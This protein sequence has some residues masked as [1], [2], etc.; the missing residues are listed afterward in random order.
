MIELHMVGRTGDGEG[1]AGPVRDLDEPRRRCG[2]AL[3]L[4]AVAC[5]P[6]L[7]LDR[8][9]LLVVAWEAATHAR[10]P[11]PDRNGPHP[12]RTPHPARRSSA[13]SMRWGALKRA[14]ARHTRVACDAR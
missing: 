13:Q 1:S 3:V 9:P 14:S 5:Q 8:L 7:A 10:G 12:R 2:S 6:P 11:D 4:T